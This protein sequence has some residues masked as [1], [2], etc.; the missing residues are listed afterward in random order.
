MNREIVFTENS[1]LL[2]SSRQL[3]FSIDER[4]RVRWQ[5]LPVGEQGTSIDFGKAEEAQAFVE[6]YADRLGFNNRILSLR[7]GE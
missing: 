4:N 3:Q 7:G 5:M 6:R 1:E 2:P